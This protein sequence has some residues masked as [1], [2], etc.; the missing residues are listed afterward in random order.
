MHKALVEL[1]FDPVVQTTL[2]PT[3]APSSQPSSAPT[4]FNLRQRAA[5]I[6]FDPAP[7]RPPSAAPTVPECSWW[8]RKVYRSDPLH[9]PSCR[10][11]A[12]VGCSFCRATWSPTRRPTQSTAPTSAPSSQPT[13]QPST[14]PVKWVP[15][16]TILEDDD[17]STPAAN[18]GFKVACNKCKVCPP[19]SFFQ[20]ILQPNNQNGH[21]LNASVACKQ[22]PM[23]K[24]Q[25]R[26]DQS[27][28]KN[29]TAGHVTLQVGSR[30]CLT[31]AAARLQKRAGACVRVRGLRAFP[32]LSG[33]YMRQVVAYGGWPSYQR[34][35][36]Q[37][38]WFLFRIDTG[39]RH[40]AGGR[41]C[42]S[43][44]LGSANVGAFV[45]VRGSHSKKRSVIDDI[46]SRDRQ[47]LM[48]RAWNGSTWALQPAVS[49]RCCGTG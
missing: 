20:T 43:A 22:C 10:Q 13:G 35:W 14:A 18:E 37:G 34:K 25:Q 15:N 29:C 33:T 4:Q 32:S 19:G 39:H 47:V 49:V 21:G 44:T 3:A 46:H 45:D 8:C 16:D 38:S 24:Y 7:L 12:C 31:L 36:S 48:W 30:R 6:G 28:C 23:G 17:L 9:F 41:W 40:N 1:G 5:A 11:Q 27:M 42:I 26:K 2:S